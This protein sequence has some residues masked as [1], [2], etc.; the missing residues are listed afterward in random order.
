[1]IENPKIEKIQNIPLVD[2][3][4]LPPINSMSDSNKAQQLKREII[5][6]DIEVE[7]K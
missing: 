7:E 5:I 3:E 1:M 6:E 4:K 2:D